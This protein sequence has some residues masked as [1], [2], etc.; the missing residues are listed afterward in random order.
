MNEYD[1]K[2]LLQEIKHWED[3][4]YRERKI[5]SRFR[6]MWM[7]LVKDSTI[8]YEFKTRMQKIEKDHSFVCD[9]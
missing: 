4:Y 7:E 3:K 9:N 5:N 1:E 2:Y 6:F 8:P